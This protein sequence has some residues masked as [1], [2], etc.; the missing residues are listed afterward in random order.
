MPTLPETHGAVKSICDG[1]EVSPS[2]HSPGS[3]LYG[4]SHDEPEAE[5]HAPKHKAGAKG[6]VTNAESGFGSGR[7]VAA[8]NVP[9]KA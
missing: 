3:H 6:H 8:K 5:H 1:L 4:G 7:R 2:A 9:K